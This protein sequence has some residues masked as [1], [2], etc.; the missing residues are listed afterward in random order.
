MRAN[1]LRLWLSSVAYT[2]LIALRRLGLQ[3]T[4][5]AHAQPATIRLKLLK[6]GARILVTVRKVWISLAEGSPYR[7]LFEA[8]HANLRRAAEHTRWRMTSSAALPAPV[9]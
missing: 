5:L 7:H 8:A 3:H 4:D 9:S 2:L 6:L 1:E